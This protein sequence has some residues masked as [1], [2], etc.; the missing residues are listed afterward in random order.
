[1]NQTDLREAIRN[2]EDSTME[3]KRDGVAN[4]DFAKELVAFLNLEGGTVLLG[5]EDDGNISGV[6]RERAEEWVTEMCRVKIEPRVIPVLVWV[7]DVAETAGMSSRSRL[8]GGRTSPTPGSTMTGERTSCGWAARP[9]KRVGRSF[10]G[11]IRRRVT[12][13]TG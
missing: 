5:V 6:E 8:H 12:S 4:H 13:S 1:M 10:S 7:R 9:A 3:F 2:G 11:C